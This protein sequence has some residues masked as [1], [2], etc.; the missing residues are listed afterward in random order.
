MIRY[1]LY[2]LFF[3]PIFYGNGQS[4]HVVSKSN[5][6]RIE[7]KWYAPSLLLDE[8]VHIFRSTDSL[9]WEQINSTPIKKFD[10]VITSNEFKEDKDLVDIKSLLKGNSKLEDL[11]KL[12]IT[13][14][15]FESIPL[16][17]YLGIYYQDDEVVKGGHYYYKIETESK[18]VLGYSKKIDLGNLTDAIKVDSIYYEQQKKGVS[19]RWLPD[20]YSYFGVNIYRSSH[21]D[22]IGVLVN[23]TPILVSVIKDDN[24]K[25]V[26]PKFFYTD[27]RLEEKRTF[28]YRIVGLD[29]FNQHTAFSEPIEIRIKD[30][31]LPVAPINLRKRIYDKNVYLEWF[32]EEEDDDFLEYQIFYST[33]RDTIFKR[34]ETPFSLE[35]KDSV[36]QV[37][38]LEDGLYFFT[39]AAIDEDGNAGYSNEIVVEILDQTPPMIPQNV[40][41]I[42]DSSR[43]II[44]WDA[45]QEGDLKGYKIYRS[46]EGQVENLSLLTA[47][48]FT[49]NFFIDS[50][51]KNAMN[52]FS[53]SVLAIDTNYNESGLSTMVSNKMIDITPPR[54]PFIKNITV[55]GESLLV[56]WVRNTEL[57]L[58]GYVLMRKEKVEDTMQIINRLLIPGD[59]NMYFDRSFETNKEYAYQLIA[60]DKTGNKSRASNLFKITLPKV[61]K[62]REITVQFTKAKYNKKLRSLQL[63]WRYEQEE[64]EIAQ[65]ILFKRDHLGEFKPL[66]YLKNEQKYTDSNISSKTNSEYQIRVY[67]AEGNIYR[68]DIYKFKPSQNL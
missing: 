6:E 68:S 63:V 48:A 33:P 23:A 7:L 61:N 39:I 28:Y 3:L 11:A 41:V 55:E 30:E 32:K 47:K 51:P 54:E 34:L 14:K 18:K 53:Y 67:D 29:F 46:I 8:S 24:G 43:L 60:V 37:E 62:E 26:Y 21:R 45:N 19:F 27:E 15:S 31:T 38:Q 40:I 4:I 12:I 35:F 22:S 9:S 16:A 1:L 50:L 59:I 65:R 56:E 5:S 13:M 36:Y 17:K 64:E 2:F 25:S 42:S 66:V 52:N 49:N 20:P 58:A 10:Y 44:Q 57:D